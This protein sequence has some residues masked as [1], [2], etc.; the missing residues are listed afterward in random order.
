MSQNYYYTVN[1]YLQGTE[2]NTLSIEAD[3]PQNG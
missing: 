2:V 3:S 1:L